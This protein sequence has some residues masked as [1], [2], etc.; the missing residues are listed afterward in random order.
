MGLR[1]PR[2]DRGRLYRGALRGPDYMRVMR[3][4][5]TRLGVRVLDQSP[6]F[7]L[8][9]SEGVVAGAAGL[10]RV[11]GARWKVNAGAVIIATGG[12]AFLS[13]ALGTYGLTG[14]GLLMAAEAGAELSDMEFSGQYGISHAAASVTKN[15]IYSW[16]T[17]TDASG[18]I[19]DGEDPFTI[20]AEN[21]LKGQY[22]QSS[23]RLPLRLKMPFVEVSPMC[24]SLWI[25]RGLIHSASGF[26]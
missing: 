23:T 18:Q 4:R 20:I 6:A 15:I 12:C 22:T 5:L 3:R 17:F 7:E 8:L 1:I 13:K 11:S 16:A 14:D 26:T 24:S 10:H 25:V 21:L 19:L 9:T 2:D